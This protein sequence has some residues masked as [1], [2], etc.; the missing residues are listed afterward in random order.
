M[1][2]HAYGNMLKATENTHDWMNRAGYPG[3]PLWITEWGSYKNDYNSRPFGITLINNLIESSFP[4]N[5]YLYG[6]TIF[7]LYD[8]SI[9][10]TGLINYK[11][12]RHADYYAIRMSIRA[13]QGCRPTY[14]S[15]TSNKDLLSITTRDKDGNIYLLV[16][17]RSS[18][19]AYTTLANLSA[20]RSNAFGTLWQFDSN[21]LDTITDN[22]FLKNGTVTFTIPPNGAILVK[23]FHSRRLQQE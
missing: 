10:P 2:I 1:D 14:Q 23:L 16:T 15:V 11:G 3:E 21:H 5:D 12:T 20:L 6:S 8:F 13:L 7:S 17:N 9:N 4:G 18:Q 19:Y 22:A